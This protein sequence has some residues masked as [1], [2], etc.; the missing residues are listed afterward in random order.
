MVF[1]FHFGCPFVRQ[2]SSIV[3]YIHNYMTEIEKTLVKSLADFAIH[4]VEIGKTQMKIANFISQHVPDLTEDEKQEVLAHAETSWLQ[5]QRL[6]DAA[7]K[8][9]VLL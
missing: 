4:M 9:Q 7:S 5:V 8:L 6:Q 1:V 2:L 3:Y